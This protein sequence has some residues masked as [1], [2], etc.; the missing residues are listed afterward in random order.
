VLEECPHCYTAVIPS[1]H[2]EC[3][4]CRKNFHDRAGTDPT[5]TALHVSEARALPPYCHGCDAPTDRFVDVIAKV[6]G[7]GSRANL[8]SW[9][10]LYYAILSLFAPFI[11][12]F[13]V[14]GDD[15]ERGRSGERFKVS[16]P[17]CAA[18]GA[19]GRPRPVRID[20]ERGLLTFIVHVSFKKRIEGA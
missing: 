3:P 16:L 18:C 5:R 9:L 11:G 7:Y 2:G 14:A 4:S 19:A 13:S 20:R 10:L 15:A 12:L 17:Q 1:A 8:G 6:P